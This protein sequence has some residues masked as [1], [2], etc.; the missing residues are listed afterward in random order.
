MNSELR[1]PFRVVERQD[2][3][4]P[5]MLR[6]IFDPPDRL[7][8]SGRWPLPKDV[9][10]I[11]I[12]GARKA[13]LTGRDAAA[14]IA[15]TLAGRGAVIVSGMAAGIDAAAHEATLDA[16]GWTIGVLGHGLG[17]QYPRE[18]AALYDRVAQEGTLISEFPY[19][20]SPLPGYF[21]QRNRI[22]SGLSKGVVVVEAAEKSG[23]LIT[24]R[25]AAEQG[26]D[27]FAVP[28]GPCQ[29]QC[30]G[31]NRL[32]K[33]GASLVETGDDVLRDYGLLTPDRK[34]EKDV[35]A[36]LSDAEQTLL[37][38]IQMTPLS[39][40]ELVELTGQAVECLAELLLS[41]ELKGRITLMPGTRYVA[42]Y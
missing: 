9:L 11:G 31:T 38:Q 6:E 13:S 10:Y 16:H 7:F 12:V 4:Y 28:G 36:G 42:R 40:D 3:S 25:C 18:N 20:T 24:A 8:V 41:L 21:P 26:R 32:I 39:V 30:R 35:F 37:K 1:R 19:D 17:F 14:R 27:V 2:E 34:S 5:D 22:I 23:A 15:E 29:P 33:E